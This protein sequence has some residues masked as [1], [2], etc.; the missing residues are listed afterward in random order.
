MDELTLRILLQVGGVLAGTGLLVV[1]LLVMAIWL[2]RRTAQ[3]EAG[4]QAAW[5]DVARVLGL[6]VQPT[7]PPTLSGTVRGRAVTVQ[8]SYGGRNSQGFTEASLQASF[9][10]DFLLRVSRGRTL[11]EQHV[12]SGD[13]ELDRRFA[14]QSRPPDLAARFVADPMLRDLLSRA[15]CRLLATPAEVRSRTEGVVGEAARL[16]LMIELAIE[17]AGFIEREIGVSIPQA[18]PGA[19]RAANPDLGLVIKVPRSWRPAV[20]VV[21]VLIAIACVCAFSLP[22]LAAIWEPLAAVF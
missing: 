4:I 14:F 17:A 1:L 22:A 12:S 2:V 18:L 10:A 21:G 11:G 15:D 6:A 7:R 5:A 19:V 13:P 3:Q 9:P 8:G 16:R 20:L